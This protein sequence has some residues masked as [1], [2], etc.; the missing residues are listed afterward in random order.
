MDVLPPTQPTR[1]IPATHWWQRDDLGYQHGQLSLAGHHLA[2]LRQAAGQPLHVLSLPRVLHKLHHL[3]NALKQ[4]GLEARILYAMKANRQPALLAALA[5]HQACGIDACSP[6]EIAL[7]RSCGFAA[8]AI[9][10]TACGLSESELRQVLHHRDIW[11]N[12]DGLYTLERLG[13]CAPGRAIGLRVNPGI[14]LGYENN[15]ALDYAGGRTTKFGLLPEQIDAARVLLRR[16][17]LSVTTL[18]VHA[19]CGYLNDKRERL[20][21]LVDAVL[22]M[23]ED[24]GASLECI[25]IGGGLGVPLTAHDAALDLQAW[26]ELL[27]ERL[28]RRGLRLEVEPGAY[29]VQDAGALILQVSG[30]EM[31]AAQP[32]VFLDGGF[33]LAPEP[34]FYQLPCY[35]VRCRAPAPGETLKT[36]TLAGNINEALDLWASA[37]PLLPVQPGD[38]VA[39]LNVGA[40][41][42]SMASDHCRRGDYSHWLLT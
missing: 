16:Y 31:R 21:Q 33:N 14:G 22:A 36:V 20:G 13:Q 29:L 9:S 7:A 26:A 3:R 15:P 12:V 32:F 38:A 4:A 30:Y 24:L 6:G 35:P 39:L 41:G 18:H 10:L 27:S 37:H 42:A 28:R 23:G 5:L 2:E 25:N 8:K 1:P 40:Y 34:A 19:G 17:R 11:L